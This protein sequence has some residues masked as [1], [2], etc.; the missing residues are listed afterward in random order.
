MWQYERVCAVKNVP[1]IFLN[2]K[3][4]NIEIPELKISENGFASEKNMK[5]Q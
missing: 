2:G 1:L 5:T 4:E 3:I